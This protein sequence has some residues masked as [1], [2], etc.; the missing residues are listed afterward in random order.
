MRSSRHQGRPISQ[1]QKAHDFRQN[2][3]ESLTLG[4]FM[5]RKVLYDRINY[6]VDLMIEQGLLKEVTDLVGKGYSMDLKSMQSIGYRHMA[7]FIR[8]EVSFDEAVRLLKRDT[9]RYAKRQFTWFKKEP[10]IIWV[11]PSEI[12]KAKDLVKEFLT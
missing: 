11:A 12:E 3:Y 5:D 2:R 9:R 7:M 8:Q 6:R 10:G 1:E 4:L